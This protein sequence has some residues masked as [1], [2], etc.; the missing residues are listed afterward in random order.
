MEI[1]GKGEY[2]LGAVWVARRVPEGYISGHANQARITTFPLDNPDDTLYASDVIS[3]ARKIG[4]FSASAPDSEFSFSDVYDPVTFSGARFCEARVW[5]MFSS[6][7][8]STFASTYLDYAQGYNLTNRMPLFVKPTHKLSVTEVMSVMRSHYE[9]TPLDMTGRLL[10]LKPFA[11]ER[12]V[13]HPMQATH[14]VMLE[15][16][17]LP[18]QCG[19]IP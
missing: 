10:L 7:T 6:V 19:P 12:N 5:S 9:G 15:H 1:I 3:F 2:E 18:L 11:T 8:D 14:S 16:H 13:N 17:F 4:V